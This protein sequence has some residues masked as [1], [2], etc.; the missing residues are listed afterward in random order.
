MSTMLRP[1]VS[2]ALAVAT[3]TFAATPG[4]CATA[5]V[6]GFGKT[7][8]SAESM[9]LEHA[10]ERVRELVQEHLGPEWQPTGDQLSI[11]RLRE[12]KVIRLNS[13]PSR[14]VLEGDAMF[15][16]SVDVDVDPN[17]RFVH[18][19][20]D[21]GLRQRVVDRQ[22]FLARGLAAAVALLLV[23]TGY[24][25]LEARTKGYYTGLLRLSAI[26]V[27][28]VVGVGLWLIR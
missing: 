10:R 11:A 3:L 16:A 21:V 19:L 15:R 5:T 28:A 12:M 7:P 26:V 18:E 2:F 13:S 20:R 17:G 9:A 27:V 6:D 8:A 22:A 24:L 4:W 25:R 23:T 1:L 14:M